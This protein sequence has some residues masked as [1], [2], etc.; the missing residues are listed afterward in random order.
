[1]RT[2]ISFFVVALLS[3]SF[4]KSPLRYNNYRSLP[5][6][7]SITHFVDG[8]INEWPVEKMETDPGSKVKYAIDNDTQD[9][10]MALVVPNFGTQLKM[11]RDGME[12]Y[13][14][15]KGKKKQG[16][17]IEFPVKGDRGNNFATN[18]RDQRNEETNRGE[19]PEQRKEN[20]KAMRAALI[21]N[22]VSMKIF[23]FSNGDAKEQGL[24]IPGSAHIAFNWDSTD[25]MCIEY[26][27]PLSL[28]GPYSS[29]YQKNISI[30]WKING[31]ETAASFNS[32]SS[33]SAEISQPAGGSRGGRRNSGA[34]S[35]NFNS[36][37]RQQNPEN[38]RNDQSFWA[39][40]TIR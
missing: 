1:M 21:L 5:A 31:A 10:Y 2:F 36:R 4:S 37:S 13:I 16:K 22:L 15:L 6:D 14:D 12:V 26:K 35:D 33:G 3:F 19:T 32:S 34:G 40:Y 17:G 11:M 7:T 23:G 18:L 27:I 39:K 8:K 29:L 38:W 9:L 25:V 28:L 20:M 24:E 30:G